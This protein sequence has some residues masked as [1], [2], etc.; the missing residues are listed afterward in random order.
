MSDDADAAL[1]TPLPV[2]HRFVET[3][4]LADTE[5]GTLCSIYYNG[6]FHDRCRIR[7]RG[8]TSRGFPKKSHKIDLPPGR[9][10]PLKPL[11]PGVPDPEQVSELNLNTTYTDKSYV[12][13]L[14]AAEMH[15][16]SGIASPEIFHIHQRENGTFY[17]VAL[18]VE[19][20]DDTFLKKHGIDEHGAFY[21]AVGDNGACDFT[22]AAAFEASAHFG[23]TNWHYV[24]LL[25]CAREGHGCLGFRG[26]WGIA[27][28]IV[29]L[30]TRCSAQQQRPKN[31]FVQLHL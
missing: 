6:E 19:N 24:G 22:T 11:V 23:D 15:A 28:I 12:R 26:L 27:C 25:R 8:N 20:V 13:A 14:M 21:K 16:L 31:M 2:F 29:G 30:P 10:V 3:P 7:M 17:S 5:G 18:C 1:T 4:A 9:R